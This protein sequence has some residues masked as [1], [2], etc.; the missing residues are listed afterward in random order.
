MNIIYK[1]IISWIEGFFRN[2]PGLIGVILRR[3]WYENRFYISD[4]F[5]IEKGC[6]FISP[7]N[8]S[9]ENNVNIGKGAFF[10][11]EGGQIKIGS[12]SMF[13]TNVHINSS[14]GG[15]IEI[16]SYVLIGPNVVMRTAGHN[17]ENSK[18][19]I[20]DQGHIIKNINIENDVWIGS[21]VVI[22]GGVKIGTGA[23]IG[24]GAV[25]TKDIPSM[26]IAM[27]VP[28]RVIKYRK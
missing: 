22:V 24:A 1:E 15:L 2:I 10:A 7:K 20:K 18:I 19:N 21:N 4:K 27:G 8:I 6:E 25:V 5:T 16:G 14:V 11:S 23:V 12:N 3:M 9:L 13:N 28:A 17:F 26:A